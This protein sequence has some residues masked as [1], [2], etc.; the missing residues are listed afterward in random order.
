MYIGVYLYMYNICIVS[1]I[2][3]IYSI[4]CNYIPNI[5]LILI[6]SVY[7]FEYKL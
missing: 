5:Y 3:Y 7:I 1:D 4:Y 6:L 2:V